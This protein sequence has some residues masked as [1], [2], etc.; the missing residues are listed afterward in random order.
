MSL[1]N[2]PLLLS[3]L[4]IFCSFAGSASAQIPT[5]EYYNSGQLKTDY[6]GLRSGVIQVTYYY[7]DGRVRETG[8]FKDGQNHG[9]WVSYR[10]D[11]QKN[12]EGLYHYSQ[13]EGN[14]RYWTPNGDVYAVVQFNN[15]QVTSAFLPSL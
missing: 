13:R 7:E 14:W 6:E 4:L 8:F 15:S 11:G 12:A 5:D 9:H 3:A 2:I 10:P 1:P